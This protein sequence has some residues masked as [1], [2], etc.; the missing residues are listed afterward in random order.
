MTVVEFSIICIQMNI[1]NV[2]Y[3]ILGA[4]KN[5]VDTI[6]DFFGDLCETFFPRKWW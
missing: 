2:V 1:L 5:Y 6:L 3:D 4:F